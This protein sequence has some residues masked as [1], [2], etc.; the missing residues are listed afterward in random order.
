MT[1][2]LLVERRKWFRVFP[3][4]TLEFTIITRVLALLMLM[5]LAVVSGLQRPLVLMALGAI[6]WVDYAL[7]MWWAIE[8]A[9]DLQLLSGAPDAAAHST[10]RSRIWL[11]AVLPSI[12]ALVAL[13]PWASLASIEPDRGGRGSPPPKTPSVKTEA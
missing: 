12:A 10:R 2:E 1:N 6:L 13:M 11:Q 8:V 7:L 9:S 4:G 5:A 3:E